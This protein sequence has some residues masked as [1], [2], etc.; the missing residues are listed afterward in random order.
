MNLAS[1]I[2]MMAEKKDAPPFDVSKK[3]YEGAS[4]EL[5]DYAKKSGGIDKNDFLKIAN[6]ISALGKSK[7]PTI[8][9]RMMRNVAGLDTDVREKIFTVLKKY[10]LKEELECDMEA[11]EEAKVQGKEVFDKTFANRTQADN[12]AQKNGGRVKQVGR[13]F[14]VFKEAPEDNEPASPDEGSMAMQQLEF[15][16]YAAEEIGDHIKAGGK[17]PEW[18]QNKLA[19]VNDNMQSLHS[20]IDHEEIEDDEPEEMDEGKSSSTGY[21]L[22][23]QRLLVCDET[24]IRSCKEEVW[25]HN[26]SKR[27]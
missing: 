18:M 2:K 1:T 11:L 15:I 9:A 25:Y 7:S 3:D 6:Q 12:F 22:V 20:Q 19:T 24:R 4:K 16:E 17:F 8:G 13:V 23:S 26:R 27:D 5:T 21:E 14:Y 10:G